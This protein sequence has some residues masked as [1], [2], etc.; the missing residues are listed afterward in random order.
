MQHAWKC[1][2]AVPWGSLLFGSC[3]AM[4]SDA[5]DADNAAAAHDAWLKSAVTSLCAMPD[6]DALVSARVLAGMWPN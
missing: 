1:P 6:T 3:S 5:A 4:A 2:I